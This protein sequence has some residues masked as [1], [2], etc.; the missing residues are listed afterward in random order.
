M[1]KIFT[2]LFFFSILFLSS[3]IIS[4]VF[5]DDFESGTA[6]SD[7]GVYFTG[8]ETVSGVAMSEAPVALSNGG[9]H[10]GYLQDSDGTYTGVAQAVAGDESMQ[11]YSI[12]AD[13]FCY[14]NHPSGSAYT[15]LVVYADSTIDTYI[16]MVADFDGSQ[17][18]RFYNNHLNMTTFQYS[19]HHQFDAADIPGGIPTEDGWH[20]M[21]VEVKTLNADTTA[22][23]CYFD[24]E[25]LAGCPI[26][27]TSDDRMASG[28]FGLFAFQQDS[29][30]I[31]GY[32]DNVLVKELPSESDELFSEDFE[33]GSASTDWGVYFTGEETVSGV[34]MSEAPSALSSGGSHVGYLQDSDGTYT[35]VAQAVAGDESMQNYSIEADVFCYVNHPSGSAY[36]GLVVYADSTI[37]TYIK[38]VADFDGS[39]R[40]RF[41][42]NHLNMT[43]FQYS[44]H[45]Q[46]DAADIPGGIP[47][48]DGWHNM[49]VEVK[50]LNADTTAFWC[51]FDGELLA[52][53][54]IYDTSDDRMAS[55]KFGLFAFQQDSDGIA[56]YFDNISVKALEPVVS[57][58][59][60]KVTETIPQEFSLKQNYP[61]PFNPTT[62]I[63]Y[64][65][66]NA[67]NVSLV[68]YDV[69]G[70]KIKTLVSQNQAPGYYNVTWNGRN[71]FGNKVNSGI[72]LYTLK[73]GQLLESKKMILMK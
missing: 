9:S 50:T 19:F 6:S 3:S 46:F 8:E 36:T 43:T 39:Q 22:F 49:K 17:R 15:G 16:K 55:G 38:M 66:E 69:L 52:G 41:Y 53:C 11:N 63:S 5:T 37:D 10:I 35:G 70:S 42:N 20:N 14:V 12:E 60:K 32:F 25:L 47:T 44:F 13:V 29:D 67:S 61:N 54:P 1:K 21:K 26:Y 45:H 28:K 40:I 27:D 68:I 62:N 24:G 71:D 33:T 64:Q 4:Q 73:A 51:Y 59:D 31:A 72:Y 30:G 57:V 18:I 56:G 58:E 65:I 2:V 48:E 23:W 34:A 7:W